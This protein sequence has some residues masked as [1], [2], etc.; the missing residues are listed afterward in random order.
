MHT[1]IINHISTN[2]KS[3]EKSGEKTNKNINININS[4]DNTIFPQEKLIS[5][6][7]NNYNKKNSRNKIPNKNY[8]SCESIL[9]GNNNKFKIKLNNDNSGTKKSKEKKIERQKLFSPLQEYNSIK[10]VNNKLNNK[11]EGYSYIPKSTRDSNLNINLKKQNTNILFS[12]KLQKSNKKN[13][14]NNK[15]SKGPKT[16]SLKRKKIPIFRNEN[17][18]KNDINDFFQLTYNENFKDKNKNIK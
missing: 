12:S 1:K 3:L 14:K 6:N 4:Q 2:K 15:K 11:K 7:K 18:T 8:S 10:Y 9:N 5:V 16:G 17:T 13:D